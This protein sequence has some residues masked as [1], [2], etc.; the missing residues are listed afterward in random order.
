MHTLTFALTQWR[1]HGLLLFVTTANN[2]S[3]FHN[4]IPIATAC[5]IVAGEELYEVTC[6]RRG[7]N[8]IKNALISTL[9]H[10]VALWRV[11]C[12]CKTMPSWRHTSQLQQVLQVWKPVAR[13]APP[14]TLVADVVVNTRAREM[15][16][17]FLFIFTCFASEPELSIAT[18]Q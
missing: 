5:H 17:F 9:K 11:L 15:C 7:E 6:C 16:P 12:P 1:S 14:C 10:T 8:L 4:V 13:Y 2:N 18:L 3:L